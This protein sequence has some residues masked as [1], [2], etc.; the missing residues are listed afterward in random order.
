MRNFILGTDWWTDCDDMVALRVLTKAAK[1]GQ[2]NL[3]GVV[4]NACMEHSVASVDGF[5]TLDGLSNI[6]IGLDFEATDFKGKL[7]NYQAVLAPFAIKYKKNKDAEDAVKLYR[8]LLSSSDEP[9]EI[10]EIGFLQVFASLLQSEPDEYSTLNGLELVKEKVKKVW[11]MAGKWDE[12]NGIEHNFANN[13][14]SRN[15]AFVFCEKCPVP[16]TFLGFE[17]GFD[18]ITGDNLD[19]C[20]HLYKA[21]CKHGSKNG[22]FSWDPMTA[23]LAI[24]GDEEKCGYDTVCGTASVN[25][26]NGANIFKVSENGLHKYVIKKFDAKYYKKQINDIIKL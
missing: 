7:S 1:S 15:G 11:V 19:K 13:E 8:R 12:E 22:R 17:I 21:M 23:I 20:D 6:P 5:L 10:L 16:V 25:P 4:I 26:E 9:V 24:I 14:R 2:I 3:I 18:V